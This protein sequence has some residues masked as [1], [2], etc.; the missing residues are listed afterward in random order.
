MRVRR[1]PNCY[2][3]ELPA[4]SLK[5]ATVRHPPSMNSILGNL[6]RAIAIA[7]GFELRSMPMQRW[8]LRWRTLVNT[9]EPHPRSA[10]R[11]SA[12]NPASRTSA[13]IRRSFVAGVNAPRKYSRKCP[14]RRHWLLREKLLARVQS[15]D[16]RGGAAS[17]SVTAAKTC[18]TLIA[19]MQTLSSH[20]LL[21]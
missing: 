7:I 12:G 9:P 8:R 16:A 1:G 10:T 2:F 17:T 14:R 21:R 6:L 19:R 5:T 4:H 3:A 15:Y 20:A 18:S 13:S 11:A